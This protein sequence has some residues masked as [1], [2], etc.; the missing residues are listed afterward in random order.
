MKDLP[1]DG[2]DVRAKWYRIGEV[3]LSLGQERRRFDG[4]ILLG[5]RH[6]PAEEF[7][8]GDLKVIRDGS[9]STILLNE[10]HDWKKISILFQECT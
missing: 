5:R 4:I 10:I 2:A 7:I 6:P 8:L 3:A 9:K 1:L